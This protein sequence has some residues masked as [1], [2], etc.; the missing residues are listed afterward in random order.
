M[1]K[2]KIE[3]LYDQIIFSLS[4]LK[5]LEENKI[6]EYNS[7]AKQLNEELK[8][9]NDFKQLELLDWF[10]ETVKFTEIRNSV[11]ELYL[12][13]NKQKY[14]KQDLYNS[15]KNGYLQFYGEVS[16]SD[17]GDTEQNCKEAFEEYLLNENI[18]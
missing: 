14:S 17:W 6:K 12:L 18:N 7:K 11:T 13:L 8:Y 3:N 2:N 10:N 9:V 16:G 1:N 15:F 4:T 5:G